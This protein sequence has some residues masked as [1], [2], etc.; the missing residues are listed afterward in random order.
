MAT[1]GSAS[2]Y[3]VSCRMVRALRPCSLSLIA[4]PAVECHL[5]GAKAI[6][7]PELAIHLSVDV[8]HVYAT[9]RLLTRRHSQALPSVATINECV[10]ICRGWGISLIVFSLSLACE[11]CRLRVVEHFTLTSILGIWSLLGDQPRA[12]FL[13]RV[14]GRGAILYDGVLT[15]LRPTSR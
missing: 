3:A 12:L 13:L 7:Q 5:C 10:S 2:A 11:P 15:S 1:V 4:A 14:L 6:L 8:D 9:Y